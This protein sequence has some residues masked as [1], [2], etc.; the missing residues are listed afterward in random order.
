MSKETL[1]T[2]ETA[3]TAPKIKLALEE[4]YKEEKKNLTPE[5]EPLTPEN[6]GD[7]VDCECVKVLSINCQ[8]HELLTRQYVDFSLDSSICMCQKRNN[9]SQIVK[10]RIETAQ[11]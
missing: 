8:I 1:S 7:T 4:K 9:K 11:M 10:I 5:P 2:S 6:I 3:K